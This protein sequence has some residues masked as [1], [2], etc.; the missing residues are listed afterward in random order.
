MT[1]YKNKYPYIVLRISHIYHLRTLT[2]YCSVERCVNQELEGMQKDRGIG[3]LRS[4]HHCTGICTHSNRKNNVQNS[5]FLAWIWTE[6]LWIRNATSG[7]IATLR[8][9]NVINLTKFVSFPTRNSENVYLHVYVIS[10]L[11]EN[12]ITGGNICK[13]LD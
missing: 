9:W 8:L 11:A 3:L 12:C 2:V 6:T 1:S 4:K 5:W 10:L 13:L 7:K